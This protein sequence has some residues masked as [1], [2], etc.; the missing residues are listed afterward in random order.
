MES[1]SPMEM[2]QTF[3]ADLVMRAIKSSRNSKAFDPNHPYTEAWQRHLPRISYRPISLLF[4]ASK[5]METL[6]L[7]TINKYILPAPDQPGFRPDHSTT[8][9]L[10][11]LTTDIEMG[12]N[13]RKPPDRTVCVAVDL[14]AAF[15]SVCHNNMLSKIKRSHLLLS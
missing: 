2:G 8:S 9:A 13:Q 7:P 6:V 5:M 15:D 1:R 11:Q 14:S 10:L 4:P 3:T 12:F